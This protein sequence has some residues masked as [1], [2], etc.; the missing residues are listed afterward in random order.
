MSSL[1]SLKE[2]ETYIYYFRLIRI[3]NLILLTLSTAFL[4]RIEALKIKGNSVIDSVKCHLNCNLFLPNNW[5]L[6]LLGRRQI[7]K[8]V[9]SV[10]LPG[11]HIF[12]LK[13]VP[14]RATCRQGNLVL[15]TAHAVLCSVQSRVVQFFPTCC[16]ICV[17]VA[18]RIK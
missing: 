4:L 9:L 14:D 1:S 3:N 6:S 15:C 13:I 11:K 5:V 17:L 16:V 8:H 10:P 12:Y 7:S 2:I 18:C